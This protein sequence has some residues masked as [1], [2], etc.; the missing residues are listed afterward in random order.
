MK[1]SSELLAKLK[2]MASQAGEALFERAKMAAEVLADSQCIAEQ[3]GGDREKAEETIK[4]ECFPDLSMGGW[5]ERLLV[6]RDKY[7]DIETW[8]Q[9]KFNLQR[10]WI[11][12]EKTKPPEPK[13]ERNGPVA[14][15]V[16]EELQN[17]FEA[18]GKELETANYQLRREREKAVDWEERC[19]DLE[20]E[21][22][23]A[24]GRIATL[25]LVLNQRPELAVA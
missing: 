1:K 12:Y 8:R 10:L 25:E 13:G 22:A 24:K 4:D 5:F 23:E 19:H 20:R 21:L 2:K 17:K 18:R 6:L 11:E 9:H 7:P 15:K 14:R 3:F 16:H